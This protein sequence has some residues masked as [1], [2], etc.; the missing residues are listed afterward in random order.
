[1]NLMLSLILTSV[2]VP[3]I[4]VL[5]FQ[6]NAKD[7]RREM[8]ESV[9]KTLGNVSLKGEIIAEALHTIETSQELADFLAASSRGEYYLQSYLL[10]SKL[11]KVSSRYLNAAFVLS[12]TIPDE[13][14]SVITPYETVGK[15]AFSEQFFG[16]AEIL[17]QKVK[18]LKAEGADASFS[19]EAEKTLCYMKYGQ[20][21]GREYLIFLEIPKRELLPLMPEVSW[22]L[23]DQGRIFAGDKTITQEQLQAIM[24]EHRAIAEY[25]DEVVF[26]RWLQGLNWTLTASYD[27]L[28]P[29]MKILLL[30]FLLPFLLLSVVIAVIASLITRS[31]YRPIKELVLQTKSIV[32]ID[33]DEDE[34]K[35]LKHGAAQARQLSRDLK[36]TLSEKERLLRYKQNRDL[37]F[38]I[39]PPQINDRRSEQSFVVAVFSLHNVPEEERYLFKQYLQER[40]EAAEGVS[41]INT[42][43]VS[44]TIIM[45]AN[46]LEKAKAFVL[47]KLE[48][49]PVDEVQIALSDSGFGL[50]SIK[51]LYLQCSLLLQYKYLYRQQR[52]LTADL[53]MLKANESYSYPLSLENSL[54]QMVLNGHTDSLTVFDQIIGQNEGIAATAPHLRHRFVLVLIGTLHRIL[55]EFYME[56]PLTYDLNKLEAEWQAEDIFEQ[57]RQDIADILN[58][59]ASKEKQED[60]DLAKILLTYIEEHYHEDIMLV[61]LAEKIN[62][63]EKYCSALFKQSVGENFK[64]YLNNFRIEKAKE[65]LL[66]Q[67]SIKIGEVAEMV[68]FN[69]ANTFIRVF[70]KHVGL[71]PKA[72]VEASGK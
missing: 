13:M 2:L 21:Q 8:D 61:D 23:A 55:R 31:L 16:E 20:I 41:Y 68:G 9:E 57:L 70:S 59:V 14:A 63:S 35:L 44:C 36:E 52:F 53:I 71:T 54:I 22:N 34:I 30:Y 11:T 18:E 29:D 10:K 1:M 56:I 51:S 17:M 50:E 26:V 7:Y 32:S 15:K 49:S 33:N 25:R 64:T 47:E 60:D 3:V 45:E 24:S 58:F 65:I 28:K 37:L 48:N 66:L 67:P 62:A 5:V 12:I 69:S 4:F 72:F 42:E 6:M 39:L 43:D 19:F 38:G 46:S 40:L 27:R